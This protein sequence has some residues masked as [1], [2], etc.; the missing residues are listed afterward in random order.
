[1]PGEMLDLFGIAGIGQ[2]R[3]SQ[4]VAARGP[5]NA[6]VDSTRVEGVQNSKVFRDFER[7][8]MGQHYAAAADSNGL[9]AG[10][11]LAHHHF[12][13]GAGEIGQ[14]V[15]LGNPVSLVAKGLHGHR[16]L[17]GFPQSLPGATAFPHRGL[18]DYTEG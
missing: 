8:V 17:N 4:L 15:V 9:G 12:R 13:A 16:Q 3:G 1:M 6:Q 2:R 7:A 10:G 11:Y 18:V 14:V 5:A